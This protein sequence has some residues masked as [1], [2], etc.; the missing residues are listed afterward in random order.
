MSKHS[1]KKKI[2]LSEAAALLGV[3]RFKMSRLVASGKVSTTEDP[4]DERVKLVDRDAI[5][6]LRVRDQAA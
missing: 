6:A 5:L 1:E 4:L 3:S 2:P